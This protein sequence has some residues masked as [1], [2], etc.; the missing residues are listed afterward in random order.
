MPAE[1]A[2]RARMS[3]LVPLLAAALV[4]AVPPSATAALSGTMGL[5][6]GTPLKITTALAGSPAPLGDIDGDGAADLLLYDVVEDG[7]SSPFSRGRVV[8]GQPAHAN[9][10]V[11]T[12]SSRVVALPDDPATPTAIGPAGDVD[13]DGTDDVL[14]SFLG[15]PAQIT[16]AVIFG[17]PHVRTIRPEQLAAHGFAIANGFATPAGDLNGDGRDD[18]LAQ[19]LD[20]DGTPTAV[21]GL[22]WGRTSR[23]TVDLRNPGSAVLEVGAAPEAP[24]Q[25]IGTDVNGDGIDDLVLPRTYDSASVVFGR[26]TW[27]PVSLTD[28]GPRGYIVTGVY[29][30]PSPAGDVT[31]D[32]RQDLILPTVGLRANV[33]PGQ[34]G[35]TTLRNGEVGDPGDALVLDGAN[36]NPLGTGVVGVGDVTGDGRGDLVVTDGSRVRLVAG[37]AAPGTVDVRS[38]PPIPGLPMGSAALAP[39]GDVDGDGR[40]DALSIAHAQRLDGRASGQDGLATLITHGADVFAPQFLANAFLPSGGASLTP[41]S[42]RVGANATTIRVSVSED[43]LAEV[44]VRRANGTTVGTVR[45]PVPTT[46]AQGT[47]DGRVNG[48]ALPAGGYVSTVTPIDPAGNRGPSRTVSFTILP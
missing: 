17:G 39:A 30:S 45:I 18:L 31:G 23:T 4:L 33:V 26:T 5:T 29:G 1:R 22:L 9:I 12:P 28:P 11:G 27:T 16:Q 25:P 46:F 41:S 3:R 8:F 2:Y 20:G 43:A 6:G 32:G 36:M 47:W 7:G 48:Q 42:F 35:T 24:G 13:G 40:P 15:R 38:A 34:S 10:D 44:V 37:R 21:Y 19:A 14:L